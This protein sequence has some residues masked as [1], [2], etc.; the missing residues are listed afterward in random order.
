M[1]AVQFTANGG[2]EGFLLY[3]IKS[4]QISSVVSGSAE[5]V[6]KL[7]DINIGIESRAFRSLVSILW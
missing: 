7:T 1:G 6:V 4:N 3:F 2:A 5:V